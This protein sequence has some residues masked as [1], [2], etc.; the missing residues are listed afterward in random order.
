MLDGDVLANAIESEL[1]YDALTAALAI[2]VES[3][4]ASSICEV[5][6]PAPVTPRRQRVSPV[7]WTVRGS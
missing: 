3:G 4:T 2:E 6:C 5:S 1:R 7:V